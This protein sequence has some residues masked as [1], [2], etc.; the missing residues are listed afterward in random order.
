VIGYAPL[1]DV[2][3][4]K[5]LQL[6]GKNKKVTDR[7]I[8]IDRHDRVLVAGAGLG[9]EAVILGEEFNA[10]TVGVDLNIN[11]QNLPSSCQEITVQRQNLM[12]LAFCE[13]AFSLVYCYHVLEQVPDHRAVFGELH[14]VLSPGGVLFI[15]FPSKHRFISYLGTAQKVSLLDKIKWNLND[16][17]ARLRGKF[18]NRFGTHAGFTQREIIEDALRLFDYVHPVRNQYKQQKYARFSGIIKLIIKTRL[19]EFIFPST[20]DICIK[21]E[22]SSG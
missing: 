8:S 2:D 1:E 15:G 17:D 10:K 9:L 4:G 11:L 20:Y 19:V 14:W 7:S 13:N 6:V 18:E 21:K 12:A 5:L 22:V 16:I 3:Q